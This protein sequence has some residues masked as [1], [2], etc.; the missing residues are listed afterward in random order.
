MPGLCPLNRRQGNALI[1][2]DKAPLV[3]YC[4]RKQ[5]CICYVAPGEKPAP[6]QQARRKQTDGVGPE[7]VGWMAGGFG[8]TCSHVRCWRPI[9]IRGLRKN[10]N[11]AVLGQRARSPSVFQMIGKPMCRQS[12]MYV[13]S[14][15]Q[16]DEYINIK[17]RDHQTPS[18]SRRA[19]T[20]SLLTKAPCAGSGRNPATV[21]KESAVVALAVIAWRAR[22]EIT[23]PALKCSR[24][25]ISLAASSTSSSISRV[26]RMV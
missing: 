26:V 5:V 8:Q 16:G 7:M 17:Q 22:R 6:V 11:A 2:S 12:M 19:L 9:G 4:Q 15:Q 10:A 25:A 21:G 13:P 3:M 24:R 1:K 20:W 14:V 18:D 23:C